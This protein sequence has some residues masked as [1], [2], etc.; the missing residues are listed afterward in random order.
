MFLTSRL[1]WR[2][3]PGRSQGGPRSGSNGETSECS[4]SSDM[5]CADVGESGAEGGEIDKGYTNKVTA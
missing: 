2:R 5:V 4:I 3:H 1:R